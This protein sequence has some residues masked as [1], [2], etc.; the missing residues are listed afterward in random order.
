MIKNINY[1]EL[2]VANVIQSTSF[3]KNALG[4][5]IIAQ[6]IC[7]DEKVSNLL[8]QG[9]ITLI[10]TSSRHFK[11]SISKQLNLHGD[12][13]KDISF[14]IT[15]MEE[16]FDQI[17]NTSF[18]IIDYPTK[19][20]YQGD[21]IIKAKIAT[22]GDVEH[23]L[24]E[25]INCS[26]KFVLPGYPTFKNGG[27]IG[28]NLKTVDHIAIAVNNLYKWKNLY[29]HGL[30]FHKF[31]QETIETEHSG[32][33]SVVMNSPNNLIKFVFVAPKKGEYKSQIE[34]FLE[35]N[36]SCGVQHLAFS[37]QDILN[38]IKQ[39]RQNGIEFLKVPDNYYENLPE[40]LKKHFKD[41]F[42]TIKNLGIL[43]DQDGDGYLQQIFTK[44][45]QTRP[46]FF[47]EVIRREGSNSFG[48]NNIMAL[49]KAV[50]KEL[51]K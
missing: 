48:R 27:K 40:A 41:E 25:K 36:G 6:D 10:L 21:I 43:L 19:I 31:Y 15:N 32:M 35:C 17:L 33:D 26:K 37:T 20:E 23:T 44:P 45:L 8:T 49:F 51:S 5:E 50:E 42:C 9:N 1:I 38:T 24:I 2:Y 4:F 13:V 3:Y 14:E 47:L 30:N 39:L 12:F 7:H 28:T 34:K 46:T 11:D 29:K 22:F 16:V 18:K